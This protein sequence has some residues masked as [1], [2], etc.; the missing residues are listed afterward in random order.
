MTS[1]ERILAVLNGEIPDKAPVAPFIQEEFLSWYYKKGENHR[2]I[3]V[4]NLAD[5]FGFDVITK[6]HMSSPYFMRKSYENWEVNVEQKRVG[7]NFLKI[8]TI[9]TPEKTFE[10]IEGVP[11]SEEYLSGIHFITREFMIRSQE[12][13]EIFK[14]YC[15]E[16]PEEERQFIL[17]QGEFAYNNIGDRGINAPWCYGG[18]FNF[19]TTFMNIEDILVDPLID[20][21]Y[22]ADY[23]N[24][25]ATK[26]RECVE[27]MVESKFD[28]IG[29]QGNM[30]NGA[31]MGG[32]HFT[33]YVLPYENFAIEPAVA[34][35]KPTIYHNCGTSK[36]LYEAYKDLNI[37]VL[38]TISE[39]P[40]GDVTLQYAKDFWQDNKLILCGTLDQVDF[41]KN[42]TKEEAYAMAKSKM[43]IGKKGG[44]FI[45]AAS[46]YIEY[47][48]PIENFKAMLEGAKDASE[49]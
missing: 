15:P 26:V 10:Q 40:V 33:E 22:Y 1:R 24:F 7:D 16:F 28:A 13:F 45:F 6:Q 41:L 11:Y 5:E 42:C 2:V 3:D 17:E 23:M 35:G 29:I 34:A 31:I 9:K 32:A 49:Y 21:D 46:D 30:A 44:K 36:G 20:E 4:C 48:T 25:F 18:V 47:G 38:E 8:T 14:K 19:A 12:D 39:A 37:T 27:V 43:E